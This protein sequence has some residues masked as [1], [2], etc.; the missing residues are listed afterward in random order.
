M[1]VM[2]VVGA[3]PCQ[4]FSPGGIQTTSPG[5]ISSIWPPQRRTRPDARRH[6]QGLAERVGVPCRP[7]ARLESHVGALHALAID[8][9]NSG[10]IRTVPVNQSLGPLFEGCE[11]ALRMSIVVSLILTTNNIAQTPRPD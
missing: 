11:P 9:L 5:R 4:C 3:A 8:G 6:D 2:A 1:W 10:S 7:G